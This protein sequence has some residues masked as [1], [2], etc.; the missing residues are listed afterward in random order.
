[1]NML[2]T[3][4]KREELQRQ[5]PRAIMETLLTGPLAQLSM[6]RDLMEAV[7]EGAAFVPPVEVSEKDGNYI[8]DVALPGFRNEDIDIEASGNEVTISGR[9]EQSKE[10][11][12][13]H[14][15]EMRQGSF[16]RTIALP[17]EVNLDTVKATFENGILRI[18]ATPKS[19]IAS[20]K[21]PIAAGSQSGAQGGGSGSR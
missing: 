20:K 15:S 16:M 4:E 21:V 11:R 8:I 6:A 17:N 19:S 1:M 10:D 18:V 14:F 3:R 13:T 5:R 12:K 7:T 2:V 9:Y